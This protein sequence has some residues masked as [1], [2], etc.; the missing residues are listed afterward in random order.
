M[1]T[2]SKILRIFLALLLVLIFFPVQAQNSVLVLDEELQKVHIDALTGLK[3]DPIG[4]DRSNRPCARIKLHVNRMSPEEISQIQVKTIGGNAIVMKSLP[5]VEGNGLIVELTALKPVR[6]Y[7]HHPKYGDSNPVE[8]DLEGNIEYRMEAWCNFLQTITVS[9]PRAGASVWLDGTFRGLIS[10]ENNALSI[11]DVMM[12]KHHLKVTYSEDSAE[13][14]IIVDEARV[15]F[16]LTL[17]SAARLQQYVVFDLQPAKALVT[18]DG[19]AL[20]PDAWGNAARLVRYG[21]HNYVV[22][23]KDYHSHEGTFSLNAANA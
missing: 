23:A 12:G 8:A 21:V 6:F 17:Q 9:C 18:L 1:K 11:P 22:E 5:A 15:F 13:Q 20:A 14:N 7:L 16:A 2:D 19:D 10:E 4:K 3:I